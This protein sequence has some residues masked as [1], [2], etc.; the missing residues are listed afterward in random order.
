MSCVQEEALTGGGLNEVVRIGS[1]VRRPTGPWTPNVHRLLEHLAPLGIA[2]VP[3]GVDERGREVLTYL[4]GE[5]GHPPLADWLRSDEVLVAVARMVRRLHDAT[6]GLVEGWGKGSGKEAGKGA[7]K[8]SVEG[9]EEW[10]G[11]QFP[12]VAPVEVICHND[13]APYNMVFRGGMPAGVFDFDG[14]RPGPRWW[15]VAYTAYCLVPFSPE[16][17]TVEDQRRRAGLFCEA[18]G[19]PVAGMGRRVLA[20]LDDMVAMIRE[21]PEFWRQREEGHEGYYLGHVE[22]VKHN[23]LGL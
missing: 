17:G 4:E 5:V 7:R 15:D 18:Y 13:L 9:W 20:R 8:G 21:R 22:Y 14:A 10:Q 2:P 12:A 19:L 3:H 6:A 11:W 16:F 1:T 23:F